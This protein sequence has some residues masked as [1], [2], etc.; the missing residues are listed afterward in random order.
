MQYLGNDVLKIARA[1]RKARAQ[2]EALT[3]SEEERFSLQRKFGEAEENCLLALAYATQSER[4][5]Y[6]TLSSLEK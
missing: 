1:L 3:L 5:L 6:G 4:S 2:A